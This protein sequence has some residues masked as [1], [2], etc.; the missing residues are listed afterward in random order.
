MSVTEADITD[1]KA[2]V[3]RLERASVNNT[4]TIGWMAG[5]LGTIKSIQ[6]THTKRMDAMDARF[7]RMDSEIREVKADVRAV[8]ATVDALREELPGIVAAAMREV[9]RKP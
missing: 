7:D 4:E 3:T 6:D 8:K 1:L 9:M 2:R 5:M